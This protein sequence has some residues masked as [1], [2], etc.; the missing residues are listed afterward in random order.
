MPRIC[1][2]GESRQGRTRDDDRASDMVPTTRCSWW[3]T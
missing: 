3:T 1:T 2:N